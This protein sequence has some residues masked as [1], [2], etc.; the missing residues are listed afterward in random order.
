MKVVI[1]A[2]FGG[3]GLSPLAIKRWAELKGRPCYFFTNVREPL[4]LHKYVPITL[5][6]T[7]KEFMWFAF[8]TSNVE[9]FTIASNWHD[10]SIE[11]RGIENEKYSQHSLYGRDIERTDL[12][13]I[14]VVEELGDK[15]NGKF[16][17]LSVVEIPDGIEWEI[18]EYDGN[19]TVEEK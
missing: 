18:D 3:F 13:L 1:N 16:A 6:Q 8:D 19:E 4:D 12:D 15:A 14:R 2:C 9:D 5:E 10:L 11:Q 17:N 7:E